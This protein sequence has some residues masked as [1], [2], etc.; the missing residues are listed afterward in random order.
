MYK[1][2]S[3]NSPSGPSRAK[4]FFFGILL[5]GI[6]IKVQQSI[7]MLGLFLMLIGLILIIMGVLDYE[8]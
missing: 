5:L 3:Q 6:G 7:D 4:M 2:N 1:N 8:G